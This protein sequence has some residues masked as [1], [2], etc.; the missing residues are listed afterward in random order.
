M[1]ND[2]V[3][4]ALDVEPQLGDFI[5][6][7]SSEWDTFAAMTGSGAACFGFFASVD[8]AGD[9]AARISETRGAFGLSLRDVG[10]SR[11][12]DPE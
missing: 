6:D 5:S 9:A 4:A 3:P 12:S 7:I 8:E 10:V 1:R 2:L 11:A